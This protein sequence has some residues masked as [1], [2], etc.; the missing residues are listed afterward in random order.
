MVKVF[1]SVGAMLAVV[2]A[3]TVSTFPTS[4]INRMDSTA[5]PCDDFYQY[6]CGSWYKNATIP[7]SYGRIDT[8]GQMSIDTE[9]V[10]EKILK[11]NQPKIGAFYNSCL[12]TET[13]ESVGASPLNKSLTLIRNA[14]TRN[15]ALRVGAMLTNVGIDSFASLSV[16]ADDKDAT[17]NSLFARQV[18]LPLPSKEYYIDQDKWA[19]VEADYK[20]YIS[21]LF[22]LVGRSPS[23]A[24]D[25]VAKVIQIEKVLAE[26]QY[27]QLESMDAVASP[28]VYYPFSLNDAATR[29]PFTVGPILNN[30]GF[31]TTIPQPVSPKNRIVFYNLKFFDKT[32]VLLNTT[33]LEDLKIFLEYK[34]LHGTA[35]HLSSAFDKAYWTFFEKK[36]KGALVQPT[37]AKKCSDEASLFL[38]DLLGTYYLKEKWSNESSKV[39]LELVNALTSSFKTGI[40]KSD[41]LD[42]WTRTN[43]LTK[44]SKI[45]PQVAGPRN[46]EVFPDLDFS[47]DT[48]LANRWKIEQSVVSANIVQI[49]TKV[50][51]EVWQFDVSAQT[52]NAFYD[53]SLNRIVIPAAILQPPFFD[54]TADP[55][56]N[57]GAIGMVLGHEI[58]H[59]FDNHGRLYDGDGNRALWWSNAT[60]SAFE[61]K[62]QCIAEQY[63]NFTAQS[64]ITGKVIGKVDGRLTLGE[65][66]AD[67]GG[68]KASFR[69]YQEYIKTHESKYTKEAGEKLFFVSMTQG[70]CAKFKD[71]GLKYILADPHPPNRFRVFGALQNNFD[72]AR[73][74]NCPADTFMNPKTKCTLWE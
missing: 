24:S 8:L 52:V 68:V 47:A 63:G 66:I 21:S 5:D 48:Y 73:V 22:Q 10:L 25:A 34:L 20:N 7:E 59:G 55:A 35:P 67:N 61:K 58:T 60:N 26:P 6:A 31:N 50:N 65:T 40:E 70:W 44:L 72:F 11:S 17:I 18:S 36:L 54:I 23:Q 19:Y 74:F 57:F 41:W 30:Y 32:E 33:S 1:I 69:A 12:D 9:A 43:A 4:V 62:A 53:P 15:E 46:P 51:K 45:L 64:E 3:G 2:S 71:A 56:Q 16:S 38:S 42:G 14:Q 39:A 37:R 27:S 49:G 29:Y 13:L 28:D